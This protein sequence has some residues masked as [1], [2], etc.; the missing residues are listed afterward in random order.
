MVRDAATAGPRGIAGVRSAKHTWGIRC[1]SRLDRKIDLYT[2]SLFL[3]A[4]GLL[5]MALQGIGGGHG[6]HAGGHGHDAGHAGHAG[7][8]GHHGHSGDAHGASHSHSQSHS[9][10]ESAV[11]RFLWG[12]ASPRVWFSVL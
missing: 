10:S 4:A 11:G 2:F 8:G 1:P 3:G 5:T 12:F 9:I 6:D 7:H